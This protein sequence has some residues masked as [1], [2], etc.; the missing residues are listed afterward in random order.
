MLPAI[1]LRTDA[2]GDADALPG[3]DDAKLRRGE[4]QSGS[5][6]QPLDGV[7]ALLL[8][9][10]RVLATSSTDV[11]ATLQ[12]LNGI[13]RRIYELLGGGELSAQQRARLS[14][15]ARRLQQL[16]LSLEP[17]ATQL[18]ESFLGGD[19]AEEQD[20]DVATLL[21]RAERA[22]NLPSSF[23]GQLPES[24]YVD[25]LEDALQALERYEQ[26]QQLADGG[27]VEVERMIARLRAALGLDAAGELEAG[28]TDVDELPEGDTQRDEVDGGDFDADA[29]AD[30]SL[31][32]VV[33]E[34]EAEVLPE[35]P[36][37]ATQL[38]E[39]EFE[40]VGRGRAQ[41][42]QIR[43]DVVTFLRGVGDDET[44]PL[45]TG[46]LERLRGLLRRLRSFESASELARRMR[47]V[48]EGVAERGE[49]AAAPAPTPTPPT[50]TPPTPVAPSGGGDGGAADIDVEVPP[51]APGGVAPKPRIVGR[52]SDVFR[53]VVR[54]S[55]LLYEPGANSSLEPSLSAH[56]CSPLPLSALSWLVLA[57]LGAAMG[58]GWDGQTGQGGQ[59]GPSGQGV[60]GNYR[61]DSD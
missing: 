5:A 31:S 43:D 9:G 45:P 30:A 3:A 52:A 56:F 12:V 15:M 33:D 58:I 6:G 10:E 21:A 22:L 38:E 2:R 7:A 57:A 26:R 24:N 18:P 11:F 25:A 54:Q 41:L 29:E 47:A 20:V 39:A 44:M 16:E 8:E 27:D 32:Q 50:P 60:W 17:E 48:L 14:S 1:F 42:E 28:L 51:A 37:P 35:G 40:E 4:G 46:S 23:E 49:V 55:F 19:D 36:G 61:S 53:G 13:Q 59:A 34:L